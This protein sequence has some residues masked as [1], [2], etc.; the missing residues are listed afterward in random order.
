MLLNREAGLGGADIAR[1]D[2]HNVV[3]HVPLPVIGQEGV[4]ISGLENLLVADDRLTVGMLPERRCEERL[5][6]AVVGIVPRHRDLAQDDFLFPEHLVRGQRRMEHGVGEHVDGNLEV[7][8]GKV[9]VIHGPVEGR[10]G[11]DVAAVRLDGRRDIAPVAP[12]GSLEQ[13]V[14]KVMGET[15]SQLDTLMDASRA[16]PDLDGNKR[17]GTVGLNEQR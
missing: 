2:D 17:R 5:P 16:D 14:L 9:D 1:N 12:R 7:L 4:A 8:A 3:R 15:G 13:H 6:H 11:V 10:V